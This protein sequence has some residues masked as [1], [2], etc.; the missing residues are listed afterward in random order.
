MG[1]VGLGRQ[2]ALL[3][4]PPEAAFHRSDYK[5]AGSVG[6]ILVRHMPLLH[7]P[8]TLD[9]AEMLKHNRVRRWWASIAKLYLFDSP[10]VPLIFLEE[11]AERRE[12]EHR[13]RTLWVY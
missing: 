8:H 6:A 4:S 9:T 10:G 13:R 12:Y 3:N 11:S 2:C 7:S 1:A 5:P